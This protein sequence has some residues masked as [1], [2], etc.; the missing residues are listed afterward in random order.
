M[1]MSSFCVMRDILITK[2]VWK[3]YRPL[4]FWLSIC[5]WNV[6]RWKPC[7]FIQGC[8]LYLDCSHFHQN[9]GSTCGYTNKE[10]IH[11]CFLR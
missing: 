11:G 1:G 6:Q 3:L 2:S 8:Q 4:H 7:A 5:L 9:I 10:G